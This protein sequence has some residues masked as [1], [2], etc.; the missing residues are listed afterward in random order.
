MIFFL[1][2]PVF[3]STLEQKNDATFLSITLEK[4]VKDFVLPA[5]N[6]KVCFDFA[7]SFPK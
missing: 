2:K 6:V 5:K 3:E 7:L 1:V 4:S